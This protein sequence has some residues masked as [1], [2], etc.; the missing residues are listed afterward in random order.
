MPEY[1]QVVTTTETQDQA[2]AIAREAVQSRVAACAQVLGPLISTFWWQGAVEE[3][4]EYLCVM[5]TRADAFEAL[6]RTI[7]RLHPYDVP[8]ILSFSIHSGATDYLAWLGSEVRP[9]E[10]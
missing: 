6:E 4:A 9:R 5:K 10:P 1:L 7:R 2:R 3:A 8:E